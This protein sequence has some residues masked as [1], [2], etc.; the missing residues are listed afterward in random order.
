[1]TVRWILRVWYEP[2]V[3]S[4]HYECSKNDRFNDTQEI[5]MLVGKYSGS[6]KPAQ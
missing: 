3:N 1:M 5:K 4:T 2:S 6:K